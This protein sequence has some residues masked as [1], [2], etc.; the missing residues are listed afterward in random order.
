MTFGHGLNQGYGMPHGIRGV[1]WVFSFAVLLLVLF[2]LDGWTRQRLLSRLDS[3][4]LSVR[5][6]DQL[7]SLGDALVD[8][9]RGLGF[10]DGLLA[11]FLVVTVVLVW[12]M[13]RS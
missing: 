4:L 12:R 13:M 6:S 5:W 3:D 11:T 9:V 10:E 2:G 8:V 7:R 1:G